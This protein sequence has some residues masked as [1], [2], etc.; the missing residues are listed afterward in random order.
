[1]KVALIGASGQAG[2]RLLA[3][4]VRRGHQ[5]TG[6]ARHPERSPPAPASRR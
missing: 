3:E 4:F 2:S 1:M 6:I 5:V